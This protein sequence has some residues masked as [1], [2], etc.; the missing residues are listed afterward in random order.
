MFLDEEFLHL[1][2]VFGTWAVVGYVLQLGLGD[3]YQFL[4]HL[5]VGLKAD[6]E[7][8]ALFRAL[9]QVGIDADA[10]GAAFVLTDFLGVDDV[11]HVVQELQ[12]ELALAVEFHVAVVDDVAGHLGV[13]H[14]LGVMAGDVLV[15]DEGHIGGPGLIVLLGLQRAK[16]ELNHRFKGLGVDVAHEGEDEVVGVLET[17]GI[18]LHGFVVVHLVVVFGFHAL[19]QRVVVVKGKHEV[20]AEGGVRVRLD[21]GH[22]RLGAGDVGLEGFVVATRRGEVEVGELQHGLQVAGRAVAAHAFGDIADVGVDRGFLACQDLGQVD[23]TEVAHAAEGD[24]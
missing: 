24:Q 22:H 4:V 15:G 1:L 11:H 5:L 21:V 9:A 16:I 6:E 14:S 18:E 3:A 13:L 2:Q 17:V 20:V 12:G 10:V 8:E 7:H 19:D 23:G